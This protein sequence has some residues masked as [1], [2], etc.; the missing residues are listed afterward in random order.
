MP[1]KMCDEII[2]TFTN[3]IGAAVEVYKWINNFILYM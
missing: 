3:S 1:G 2:Y